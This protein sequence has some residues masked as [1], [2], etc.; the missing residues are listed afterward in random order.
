MTIE[1]LEIL[2]KDF[3]IEE[4]IIGDTYQDEKYLYVIRTT[5]ELQENG[6]DDRVVPERHAIFRIEKETKQFEEIHPLFFPQKLLPK[7]ALPTIEGIREGIKKRKFINRF[8]VL[9]VVQIFYG[10]I[11]D[12]IFNFGNIF[13]DHKYEREIIRLHFKSDEIQERFVKFLK[14]VNIKSFVNEEG[15]LILERVPE[16]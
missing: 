7:K 2:L 5:K 16:K 4:D 13:F 11:D 8:D 14:D 1:A 3:F 6:H 9:N 15:Y 12:P 10:G